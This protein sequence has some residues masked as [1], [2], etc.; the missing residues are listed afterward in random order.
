VSDIKIN[1]RIY[2]W[3]EATAKLRLNAPQAKRFERTV[4]SM[5][6]IAIETRPRAPFLHRPEPCY[7]DGDNP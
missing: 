3:S 1:S 7:K 5:R 4:R 6:R 2:R